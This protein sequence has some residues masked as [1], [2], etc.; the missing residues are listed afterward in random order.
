MSSFSSSYSAP[1]SFSSPYSPY[2]AAYPPAKKQK[3]MSLTQTYF[4]AHTA[5]AKLSREAGRPDHDLR[6]LVGHANMLDSL[7][8]ELAEAEKEQE[9]WFNQ[10]VRGASRVSEQPK[11]IQWADTLVEEPEDDWD[12]EDASGSDSD[13]DGS[14]YDEDDLDSIASGYRSPMPPP[15][16]RIS[17]REIIRYEDSEEAV[18]DDD[19]A[20]F[21]DL[22]LTRTSSRSKQQPPELLDDSDDSSEDESM[23][24]SPPQPTLHSFAQSERE[25]VVAAG[26]YSKRSEP[27]AFPLSESDQTAFFEEGFYLPPRDTGAM[28]EAF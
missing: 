19:E 1:S 26:L 24:P 21:D 15:S 28:I 10:S 23:P 25:A 4:L 6:V 2:A 16:P 8:L 12:P 22:A 18:E 14:D 11:H 7:M 3:K 17:T 13:S 20:D 5:R 27:S 9:R